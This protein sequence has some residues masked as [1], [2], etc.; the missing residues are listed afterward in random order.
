[1]DLITCQHDKVRFNLQYSKRVVL[2][3]CSCSTWS[4][5]QTWETSKPTSSSHRSLGWC[6]TL[7]CSGHSW[8]TALPKGVKSH[9]D[10]ET[11]PTVSYTRHRAT[12]EDGRWVKVH[13]RRSQRCCSDQT[14]SGTR[15][16][17]WSDHTTVSSLP[18]KASAE[19][20]L[21]HSL[22]L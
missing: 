16:G 21:L 9:T 2:F 1:M 8:F 5:V 11:Q 14:C 22:A 15:S 7:A 12:K 13:S 20:S 19:T 6:R 3:H 18:N 10:T 4:D 17:M